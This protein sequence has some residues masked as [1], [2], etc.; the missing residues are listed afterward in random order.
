MNEV[1]PHLLPAARSL[2][3]MAGS[4]Q[5]HFFVS[6]HSEYVTL[7]PEKILGVLRHRNIIVHGHPFTYDYGW[8]LER[9]GHLYDV[10]RKTTIHG[11]RNLTKL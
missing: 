2:N 7:T 4:D 9:F 3:Y 1:P 11:E 6:P 8:N 5:S 10:D